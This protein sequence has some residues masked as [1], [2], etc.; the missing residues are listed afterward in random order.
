[1]PVSN[2]KKVAKF[3]TQNMRHRYPCVLVDLFRV[4]RRYALFRCKGVLCDAAGLQLERVRGVV[5]EC[6]LS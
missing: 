1:M 2:R 4:S 3:E 6:I 5:I